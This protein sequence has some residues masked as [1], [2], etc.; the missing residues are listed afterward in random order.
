MFSRT[1]ENNVGHRTALH[2][3]STVGH[4]AALVCS[5]SLPGVS[6]ILAAAKKPPHKFPKC[7]LAVDSISPGSHYKIFIYLYLFLLR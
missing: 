5:H 2:D 1:F 4:L 7:T 6:P 3:L